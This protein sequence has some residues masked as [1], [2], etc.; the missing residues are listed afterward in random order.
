MASANLPTR[1]VAVMVSPGIAKLPAREL[2]LL[3]AMPGSR[4]A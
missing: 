1:I 3:P 2:R 4:V